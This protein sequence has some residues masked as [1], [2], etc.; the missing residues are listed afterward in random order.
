MRPTHHV[1]PHAP[2]PR[3]TE[4]T[5]G[6]M[7]LESDK[8]MAGK[9][10]SVTPRITG[11]VIYLGPMIRHYGLY[12]SKTFRDG[13]NDQNVYQAIAECPS[14]LQMIVPVEKIAEVLH[15][16]RFDYGHNMQGTTGRYVT[17]Y[18]EIQKWLAQPKKQ[19][20]PPSVQLKK[21]Y[22]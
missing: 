7:T 16:L 15:Q 5:R 13:I 18:R 8:I 19:P 9:T 3:E 1:E 12:Y 14:V 10:D 17:F 21:Q 6:P 4:L 2:W 20:T 11:Q 22:A